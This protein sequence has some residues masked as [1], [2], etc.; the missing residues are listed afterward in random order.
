MAQVIYNNKESTV[1]GQ[2]L[3]YGNYGKHLNLFTILKNLSQAINVLRS[4]TELKQ[5]YKKIIK[6][7]NYNKKRTESYINRKRKKES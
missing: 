3:F 5:L 2:I 4:V 7:I 1:T 6:N